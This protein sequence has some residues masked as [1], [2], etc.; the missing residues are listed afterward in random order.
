MAFTALNNRPSAPV[1]P[2]QTPAPAPVPTPASASTRA[3]HPQEIDAAFAS[4][5]ELRKRVHAAIGTFLT[6][7]IMQQNTN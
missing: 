7:E 1:V 2:V 3:P 5:Q 4:N 6:G